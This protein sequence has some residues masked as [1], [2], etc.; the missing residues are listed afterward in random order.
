MDSGIVVA[1]TM[2]RSP[3]CLARNWNTIT[4]I[5]INLSILLAPLRIGI[6]IM[7]RFMGLYSLNIR[8]SGIY[9]I[10]AFGRYLGR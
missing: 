2:R 8:E 9:G 6:N 4:F 7:I 1:M 5:G 3:V 10:R